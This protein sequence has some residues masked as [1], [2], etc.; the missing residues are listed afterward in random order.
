MLPKIK[1]FYKKNKKTIKIAILVIIILGLLLFTY[2]TLFYSTKEKDIYGVRLRGLKDNE[3][4]D[5]EKKDVIDKTSKL[6]KVSTVK[7]NVKGRLIKCFVNYEESADNNHI[8]STMN[9]M[10][11]YFSDKVKGY[12]DITFYAK[13]NVEDKETYPLIGYKHKT[14]DEISFE[15]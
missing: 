8:K 5:K 2:K 10:L 1:K 9:E 11:G 3:F 6:D 4:T 7:I 15:E 12:Y 14:R 13:K